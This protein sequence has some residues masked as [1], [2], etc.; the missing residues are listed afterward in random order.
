[1]PIHDWSQVRSGKF[2]HF[3]NSW[4]YKLS[5]RLNAGILPPGFYAAGE[6]I[7][8]EIE[9]DLVALEQRQTGGPP[10]WHNA[11]NVVAV[12]E[13]PPS[14]SITIEAEDAI[15]LRKSDRVTIRAM[16]NDRL[17]ALIEIVSGGNKRSHH[18]M[19]RLLRKVAS[20]L[21]QGCHLLI[22]DLFP[23]GSFDRCGLHVAIWEY[24][25]SQT[26][27]YSVERPLAVSSYRALPTPM[28]YVEP[29]CV[30]MELPGMPLFLDAGW[31]VQVPLEETYQ[32]AWRGFPEPWRV[33][34]AS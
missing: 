16:D 34:L 4:I 26:P 19:D 6:Q 13:H 7:V 28:A 8:G 17:V 25:F 32:Q 31:Y 1:M 23:P 11:S 12:A 9:P 22:I 15:L 29:L 2:H 24:L 14:V 18:E 21:D 3:H 20:A 30:G 10:P 5:D 27:Q 33:E